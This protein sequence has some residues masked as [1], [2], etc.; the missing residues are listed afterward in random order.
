[1]GCGCKGNKSSNRKWARFA[2]PKKKK[3][4]TVVKKTK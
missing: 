4:K 1:M 2:P 3:I